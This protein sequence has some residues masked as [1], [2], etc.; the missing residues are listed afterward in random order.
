MTDDNGHLSRLWRSPSPPPPVQNNGVGGLP[1]KSLCPV[2][3]DSGK[4]EQTV[5]LCL[6]APITLLNFKLIQKPKT[7]CNW[8]LYFLAHIISYISSVLSGLR[9]TVLLFRDIKM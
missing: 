1:C 4:I 3:W 7:S 6:G 5:C 2:T 9:V 8:I